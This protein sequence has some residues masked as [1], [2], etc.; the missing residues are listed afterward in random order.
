MPT[1]DY[2]CQ[3]CGHELEMFQP[4]SERPKRKCPKCGTL[5][6]KRLIGTG[7]GFVF[8]GA[9]FYQTDYR[10]QSYKDGAKA[11]QKSKEEGT[12]SQGDGSKSDASKK[13]PAAD[14]KKSKPKKKSD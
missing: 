5:R 12:Q 4:M 2:V 8:K 1:Y 10:S 7:A 14:G 11:E 3:G 13:T 6:L 9:G